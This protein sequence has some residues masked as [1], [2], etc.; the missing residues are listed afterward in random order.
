MREAVAAE[1]GYVYLGNAKLDAM[2][3][4]LEHLNTIEETAET[5]GGAAA[6]ASNAK[7]RKSG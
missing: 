4:L 5:G 6:A 1:L 3:A 2:A 7:K